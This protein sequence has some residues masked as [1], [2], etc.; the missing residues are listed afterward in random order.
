MNTTT[1]IKNLVNVKSLLKLNLHFG[2]N[3]NKVSNKFWPELKGTYNKIA[4]I[5]LQKTVLNM[6]IIDELF[7]KIISRGGSVLFLSPSKNL[8]PN[9]DL[10]KKFSQNCSEDFYQGPWLGGI[11]TNRFKVNYTQPNL[12]KKLR[13][14]LN[15]FNYDALFLLGAKDSYN[16]A[17]QEFKKVN[18]SPVIGLTN[19]TGDLNHI[20]YLLTGLNAQSNNNLHINYFFLSFVSKIILF[21]KLHNVNSDFS[22]L[23]Y[24]YYTSYNWLETKKTLKSNILNQYYLD[25]GFFNLRSYDNSYN[26]YLNYT[27]NLKYTLHRSENIINF[28]YQNF[29]FKKIKNSKSRGLNQNHLFL[30]KYLKQNKSSLLFKKDL[31][32]THFLDELTN[33]LFNNNT[34]TK[35]KL[36]TNFKYFDKNI[37]NF[38]F[39]RL[40]TLLKNSSFLDEFNVDSDPLKIHDRFKGL[41]VLFKRSTPLAFME[42]LDKTLNKNIFNIYYYLNIYQYYFK[43]YN[44]FRHDVNKVKFFKSHTI[45]KT[46]KKRVTIYNKLVSKQ[47]FLTTSRFVNFNHKLK[48]NNLVL[49]KQRKL[50]LATYA[51]IFNT[52]SVLNSY[53]KAARHIGLAGTLANRLRN[54]K[55]KAS[56]FRTPFLLASTSLEYTTKAKKLKILLNRLAYTSKTVSRTSQ[57]NKN[58][59]LQHLLLALPYLNRAKG[60]IT[61]K[62]KGLDTKQF[63]RNYRYFKFPRRNE[64]YE[65]FVS[66]RRMALK[67]RYRTFLRRN[68]I[69]RKSSIILNYIYHTLFLLQN[70]KNATFN[71][72]AEFELFKL[73][74][75]LNTNNYL[76]HLVIQNY[77]IHLKNFLKHVSANKQLL[78]ILLKKNYITLP[79]FKSK[80][81]LKQAPGIRQRKLYALYGYYKSK[82]ILFKHFNKSKGHLVCLIKPKNDINKIKI[83]SEKAININK[84]LL[85][86]TQL[87]RIKTLDVVYKGNTS[88]N[89][90]NLVYTY[91]SYRN[92]DHKKKLKAQLRKKSFVSLFKNYKLSYI[93]SNFGFLKS[94]SVPYL[95]RSNGFTRAAVYFSGIQR[96]R[97][98][99]VRYK[100]KINNIE[101]AGMYQFFTLKPFLH[102]KKKI[103]YTPSPVPASNYKSAKY[104]EQLKAQQKVDHAYSWSKL[105]NWK[106]YWSKHKN[107]K[108]VLN[109]G[110]M[111][112]IIR[113][114]L[115]N[116]PRGE[117]RARIRA[118]VKNRKQRW[119]TKWYDAIHNKSSSLIYKNQYLFLSYTQNKFLTRYLSSINHLSEQNKAKYVKNLKNLKIISS[120]QLISNFILH[121][122]NLDSGIMKYGSNKKKGMDLKYFYDIKKLT[123]IFNRDNKLNV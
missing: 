106:E 58:G 29:I 123:S 14:Y 99:F 107:S 61:Y 74:Y 86:A 17:L 6:Q 62:L 67:K 5:N 75:H 77:F 88:N 30:N 47:K 2:G 34:V 8:N 72:L 96:R 87:K 78:K 122:F 120:R 31:K 15:K 16:A 100:R 24:N 7:T 42:N 3:I 50:N 76:K 54:E 105:V 101:R 117:E 81:C 89:I 97:Q 79:Y 28:I 43:K 121:M 90:S 55:I 53:Q 22:N 51:G 56:T 116:R 71:S 12:D 114:H 52:I 9:L 66:R 110:L 36:F 94:G 40:T 84:L 49:T 39:F 118:N 59:S 68:K 1:K 23:Y 4:I 95:I 108:N 41:E 25:N 46:A 98:I 10:V 111:R 35:D 57:Y 102:A 112:R 26:K 91:L 33:T 103:L 13:P 11:L 37:Y 82:L 21:N 27:S 38:F 92:Q 65:S 104:R 119:T 44:T 48:N 60:G 45:R 73:K 63:I 83:K 64:S 93:K 115:D 70:K 32:A 18:H 19:T 113:S 69:F 109:K 85:Q 20:D 80:N